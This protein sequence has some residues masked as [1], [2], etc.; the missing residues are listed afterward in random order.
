MRNNQKQ[1]LWI[2]SAVAV[3]TMAM[4]VYNTSIGKYADWP[5]R[6][7]SSPGPSPAVTP[8]APS[9][10]VAP[11][12]PPVNK[13]FALTV[14][15]SPSNARIEIRDASGGST[16]Y[17]PGVRLDAGRYEINVAASGYEAFTDPISLDRDMTLSVSLCRKIGQTQYRTESYQTTCD[18]PSRT[19]QESV[20]GKGTA[21]RSDMESACTSAKSKARSDARDQCESLGGVFYYSEWD[22][23]DCYCDDVSRYTPRF[24]CEADGSGTCHIERPTKV[25]CTQQRQ[26]PASTVYVRDPQCSNPRFEVL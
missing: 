22:E 20:E 9:P 1:L 5:W 19:T 3:T 12:A 25:P 13:Q 17:R 11:P 4:T 21:N 2:L 8:P 23:G 16:V 14:K 24:E 6:A 10:V 7:P 18:G 26:V 15:P